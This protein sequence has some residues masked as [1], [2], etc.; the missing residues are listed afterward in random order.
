MFHLPNDQIY[1]NPKVYI[2]HFFAILKW[3]NYMFTFAVALCHSHGDLVLVSL[4]PLQVSNTL[5][6]LSSIS[7]IAT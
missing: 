3:G 7:H 1:N 4:Y 2:F 6:H 5:V